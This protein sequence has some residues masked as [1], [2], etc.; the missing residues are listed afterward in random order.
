VAVNEF[1]GEGL[2]ATETTKVGMLPHANRV[3]ESFA[4]RTF[5]AC[6]LGR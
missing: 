2:L 6:I 5:F 4:A 3:K 1:L